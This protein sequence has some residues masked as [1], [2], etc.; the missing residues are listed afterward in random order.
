MEAMANYQ[1]WSF[2]E[3]AD[4][5]DVITL[6]QSIV[7]LLDP[8]VET[9]LDEFRVILAKIQTFENDVL[10]PF[11]EILDTLNTDDLDYNY[12][13][14]DDEIWVDLGFNEI[15]ELIAL[16]YTDDLLAIFDAYNELTELEQLLL[17]ERHNSNYYELY[18]D[19]YEYFTVA[20]D[21]E[22]YAF[23]I[24]VEGEGI[25]SYYPYFEHLDEVEAIL[26][27]INDLNDISYDFFT[28]T[29]DEGEET[30]FDY[31]GYSYWLWLNETLPLLQEGK[32][33][34]DQIVLI[35]DSIQYDEGMA[36]LDLDD[37]DAVLDMYADYLL[38]SEEAQE[39]LDPAYISYIYSLALETLANEVDD[40][41]YDIY[42]IE[43]EEGT[44]G[45]FAS[46]DDILAALAK[47]E[48]LSE[49]ALEYL[50]E[51]ALEY[52]AYLL[53][54][55]LPLAEGLDVFN[56]IEEIEGLDL[57]NL[58]DE[59]IEA[60]SDM[61]VDYLALSEEAKS[62]LDPEYVDYLVSLVTDHVENSV[63]SIA[64]SIEEFD[65]LYN[66]ED[67]RED[68]V[69]NLLDAYNTYN[70][71][72]EDV[73]DLIDIE[74]REQLEAFHARYLVLSQPKSD[75]GMIGLILVHLTAGAYFVYKK[76]KII[77]VFSK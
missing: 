71:L 36:Y 67:I 10:Q 26:N 62:L 17:A 19:Y 24:E 40:L 28:V 22:L 33:V 60:I 3:W 30:Y 14:E 31:T 18:Y 51:E 69:S 57:D 59:T 70:D 44:Y 38:L 68:L 35:E 50:S 29:Y 25:E 47:F 12:V 16:S 43:D 21:D 73:K 1:S 72:P 23:F 2:A 42:S 20:Y 65:T 61:Y 52:Y 15:E 77:G 45:L 13:G 27:G 6:D 49:D 74:T 53:S 48:A 46:Y 55:K 39:L 64:D 54:I 9:R 63:N 8:E 7:D 66:D 5:E 37:V 11:V 58:N 76:R 75:I 4:A 34:Y 41:A 56:Q 32:E